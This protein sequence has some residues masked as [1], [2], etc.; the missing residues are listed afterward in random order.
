MRSTFPHKACVAGIY[1]HY[2]ATVGVLGLV[3][4]QLAQGLATRVLVAIP[5]K[6]AP[7]H[8]QQS[9]VTA[10]FRR[11][12]EASLKLI[13]VP[14]IEVVA[15]TAPQ[16]P[17]A[18]LAVRLDRAESEQGDDPAAGYVA[19]TMPTGIC[20]KAGCAKLAAHPAL[21]SKAVVRH[22]ARKR[23][24]MKPAQAAILRR[25]ADNE[26]TAQILQRSLFGPG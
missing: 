11:R 13:R 10:H 3:S 19:K 1:I 12:A 16:T 24:A 4:A 23:G 2:F 20:V 14:R 25:I 18:L 15:M 6:S 5:E 22:A 26:T 17:A 7:S 21:A 8:W 9:R